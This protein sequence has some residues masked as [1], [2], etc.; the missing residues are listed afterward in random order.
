MKILC[1]TDFSNTSIN[2]IDFAV[3]LSENVGD[4]EIEILHCLEVRN[5]SDVFKKID[6]IM[7]DR[8]TEDLHDLVNS[9]KRSDPDVTL[10]TTLFKASP[11]TFIPEYA[12]K[13]DFDLIVLGSSGLNAVKDMTIGSLTETL[14][15]KA[16][17]PVLCI[18]PMVRFDK[19][20][21]LVIG[22]S[23][24]CIEKTSLL[25]AMGG[26]FDLLGQKPLL[27]FAIVD[28]A[29]ATHLPNAF[30]NS[31]VLKKYEWNQ[32]NIKLEGD[33]SSSLNNFA[34]EISADA[35]VL[36][37]K[38]RS[39]WDRIFHRSVMKEELFHLEYPLLIFPWFES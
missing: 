25:D 21:S 36:M 14:A 12:L 22:L 30:V 34:G 10:K 37:H 33:V 4:G 20:E 6:G 13:H 9:T 15:R 35:V 17:C 19:L 18:P 3:K 31:P 1:P 38:Q 8:A 5:R 2:A 28:S 16:T 23:Q 24:D 7:A 39:F 26:F 11:K 32:A 27:N 29:Q